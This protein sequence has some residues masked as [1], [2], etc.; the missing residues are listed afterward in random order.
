MTNPRLLPNGATI[1]Q[2]EVLNKTAARKG[3]G[4]GGRQCLAQVRTCSLS[5]CVHQRFVLANDE[6]STGDLSSRSSAAVSTDRHSCRYS[7]EDN[8][9]YLIDF[10]EGV[11]IGDG[12]IFASKALYFSERHARKHEV[13]QINRKRSE[14]KLHLATTNTR[15]RW[16]MTTLRPEWFGNPKVSLKHSLSA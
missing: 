11:G 16:V 8:T 14:T 15:Y 7:S 4:V 2:R 13:V 3:P 5:T 1:Y 9:P 12:I 6:T 10:F